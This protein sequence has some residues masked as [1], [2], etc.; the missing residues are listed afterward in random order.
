MGLSLSP[1]VY[2]AQ[3]NLKSDAIAMVT[4]S[5]NEN[6]WTGVKNGN[7]KGLTHAPDEMLELKNLTLNKQF[8]QGNGKVKKL[9]ILNKFI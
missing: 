7:K 1:M 5:H 3:F 4:A 9:K 6:G 2:Y 8:V